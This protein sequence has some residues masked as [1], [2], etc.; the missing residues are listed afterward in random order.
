LNEEKAGFDAETAAIALN[1]FD[2]YL[3]KRK[4]SSRLEVKLLAIEACFSLSLR[5]HDDVAVMQHGNIHA[6]SCRKFCVLSI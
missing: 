5:I 2:R 6:G 3:S 1:F 4:I